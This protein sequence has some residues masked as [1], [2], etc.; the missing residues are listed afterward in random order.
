M[1]WGHS[2]VLD[3]PFRG[4]MKDFNPETKNNADDYLDAGAGAITDTPERIN[5]RVVEAER[6]PDRHN[7]RGNSG[8]H[9]YEFSRDSA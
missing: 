4:Q 8:V 9:E 2:S 6:E 5:V 7:W 1:M 3:G